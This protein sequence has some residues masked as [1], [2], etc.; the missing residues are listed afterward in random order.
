MLK[1][2]TS[3]SDIPQLI[4]TDAYNKL[5]LTFDEKQ[6]RQI[7]EMFVWYYNQFLEGL[8]KEGEEALVLAV[9]NFIE[10][11]FTEEFKKGAQP[12]C[13]DNP[14]GCSFCCHINLDVHEA[15]AK[16]ALGYAIE[17]GIPIDWEQVKMQAEAD[18][19]KTLPYSQK[20]CAFLQSDGACGVYEYRPIKCRTH[21]VKSS[22]ENCNTEHQTFETAEFHQ[23]EIETVL[24]ILLNLLPDGK[25]SVNL[26]KM[27][28]KLKQ[29]IL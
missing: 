17:K 14:K 22:V 11:K 24:S 8:L 18:E 2:I 13:F 26:P 27:L 23:F 3:F 10:Q 29:Q 16:L 5:G 9:Y 12:T 21:F 28:M 7:E 25:Q 6:H 1:P 20:R 15:E 4:V 19:Y